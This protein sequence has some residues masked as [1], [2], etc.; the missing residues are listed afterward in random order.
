MHCP[1]YILEKGFP[2][3]THAAL[4]SPVGMVVPPANLAA[5]K[6]GAQGTIAGVVPGHGSDVYW[7]QHEA[8]EPLAPYCYTEFEPADG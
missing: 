5:R 1:T 6:A 8:G 7:V 3:R 2:V 4:E